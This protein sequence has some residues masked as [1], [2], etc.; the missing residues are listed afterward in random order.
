MNILL[1]NPVIRKNRPPFNFP[2][3]LGI[4]AA[5][6]RDRG[7]KVSVY[8]QNA[9]RTSFEDMYSDLKKLN[10]IDIIGIGG[11]I[12]VYRN[13]KRIVPALRDIFPKAKIIAG[14]GLTV[15]PDIVFENI[16][17]DFCV[18]GEGEHTFPQLCEALENGINKVKDIEGISYIEGNKLIITN[19]RLP[20]K[21]LDRFPMPAYD[22]FPSEIYFNNNLLKNFMRLNTGTSR[23]ATIM[24]SRGCPYACS[25]CWRMMG[26]GTR[27]R[28]MDLVFK[29]IDY[30]RSYY[31][32]DSYLF[33]D[34]CI[35][36]N[37]NKAKAFANGLIESGNNL[38]WYSHARVNTFTHE[39]AALFKKAGCL[40]LNFG[41]ESG[42]KKILKIMNKKLDPD[43]AA[44][45]VM[46]AKKA[47]IVPICTFILGMPGENLF[48][49]QE[50]V[51]WII[52]NRLERYALFFATPFPGCDL[53]NTSLAQK[54]IFERYGTKDRY[55][56]T[57]G[58]V[59]DLSINLTKYPDAPLIKIKKIA[60][61]II[62]IFSLSSWIK[63]IHNPKKFIKT[64]IN[65]PN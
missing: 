4:I 43:Q 17:P 42:S 44:K 5:I 54:R 27:Y 21:N 29:E 1:I 15:D 34:E 14:G 46:A 57:L 61:I 41:I 2:L 25:F 48:T 52:K 12:T 11:L 63:L 9:L 55:F 60:D 31:N 53:Y 23:T 32:I 56:S 33:V 22:L 26:R 7:H 6:M 50:T 49:I 10:N 37:I 19:P 8:D 62:N 45:A 3:G 51:R 18:H 47:G 16:N 35:N 20:E 58:D 30:L 36:G 24:W 59:A 40:G 38:P 65:I 28:S 64:I 13:V 39:L